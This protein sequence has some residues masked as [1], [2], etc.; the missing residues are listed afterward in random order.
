MLILFKIEKF[1]QRF[2]RIQYPA[3]SIQHPAS[4]IQHPE[5]SIKYPASAKR[6]YLPLT[7]ITEISLYFNPVLISDKSGLGMHAAFK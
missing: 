1:H 6:L 4:R 3:S 7:S 5:S 2:A